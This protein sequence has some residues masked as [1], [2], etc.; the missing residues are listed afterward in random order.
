MVLEG[1]K[2]EEIQS[3]GKEEDITL[4]YQGRERGWVQMWLI[5]QV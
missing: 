1:E 5:L 2:E 3:M 4:H